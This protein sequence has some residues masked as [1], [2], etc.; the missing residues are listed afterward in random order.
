MFGISWTFESVNISSLTA[1]LTF[2]CLLFLGKTF[3]A[4]NLGKQ[5]TKLPRIKEKKNKQKPVPEIKSDACVNSNYSD[6][7]GSQQDMA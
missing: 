2:L 5:T 1:V 3:L 4:G 6:I 7:H